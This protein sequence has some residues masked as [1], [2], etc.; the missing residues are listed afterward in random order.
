[1]TMGSL[2][3]V[4]KILGSFELVKFARAIFNSSVYLLMHTSYVTWTRLGVSDMGT[5][6]SVGY[7]NSKKS[8]QGD[9][10]RNLDTGTGT[11]K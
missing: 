11:R 6:S 7:G 10:V 5:D 9:S 4:Y 3:L 8:E 1:M 2:V